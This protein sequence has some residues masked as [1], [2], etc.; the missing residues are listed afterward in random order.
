VGRIRDPELVVGAL[1]E[2]AVVAICVLVDVGADLLRIDADADLG[3]FFIL[4]YPF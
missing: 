1:G 3:D 2:E 4:D